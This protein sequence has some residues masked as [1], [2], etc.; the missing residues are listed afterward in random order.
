[1]RPR[2][3]LA[4]LARA[5]GPMTPM[6]LEGLLRANKERAPGPARSYQRARSQAVDFL[7]DKKP[8][9]PDAPLRKHER[10][11]VRALVRC[12]PRMPE[13]VRAKRCGRE[14]VLWT[15]GEIDVSMQPDVVLEGFIESGALKISLTKE[16]LPRG[17]G[18]AMAAL[19]WNFYANVLGEKT[20]KRLR[21]L[22]YEPRLPW[23]HAPPAKV[24]RV[25]KDAALAA[26]HIAALWPMFD[27]AP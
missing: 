14:S 16:P 3:T 2:I 26:R 12:P 22:V 17:V 1:V 10:D 4:T 6:A 5:M 13:W 18:R 20:T 15:L 21:C 8:F 9:D 25:L 23:M 7:V 19:M 24:G 27:R 11:A